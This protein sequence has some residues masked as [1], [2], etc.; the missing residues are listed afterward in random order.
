[1][2]LRPRGGIGDEFRGMANFEEAAQASAAGR[3]YFRSGGRGEGVMRQ[4]IFQN[5]D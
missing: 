5:Q 3:N 1:L 4:V 2:R